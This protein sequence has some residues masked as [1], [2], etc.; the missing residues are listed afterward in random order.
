MSTN[1]IVELNQDN[2]QD[3]AIAFD[4]VSVVDFWS[5]TCVP[6]KQMTRIL[7]EIVCDMPTQVRIS[8]VNVDQNATL[9]E[10]YNIRSLPTLLF[11]KNGV[12]QETKTGV[13]RKQVIRKAI[14]SYLN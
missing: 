5:S 4:G 3:M 12:L 10:T 2:F 14:E 8:K 11:F 1:T 9:V 7:E 13:D 6:C